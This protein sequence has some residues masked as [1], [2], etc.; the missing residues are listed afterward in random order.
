M[1]PFSPSESVSISERANDANYVAACYNV[2][3]GKEK[4][5]KIH[6]VQKKSGSMLEEEP[7]RPTP[8]P[9]ELTRPSDKIDFYHKPGGGE[10]T[11]GQSTP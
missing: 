9:P 5:Q 2:M 1:S 6:Y 10:V 4:Y 11:F 8:S 7:P 3:M